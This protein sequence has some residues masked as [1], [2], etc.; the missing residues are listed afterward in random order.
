MNVKNKKLAV[1]SFLFLLGLVFFRENL[2]L[3]INAKLAKKDYDRSYSYWFTEFF[4]NLS[5]DDLNKW[6]WIVSLSFTIAIILLTIFTLHTWYG[7]KKKTT[8]VLKLFSLIII[9]MGLIGLG[10]MLTVGFEEVYPLLRRVIGVFHSPIPL[11]ILIFTL[12]Y[13]RKRKVSK[14][15]V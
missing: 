13:V 11:F 14:L 3:T 4:Q 1:V 10:G 2:L 6:K 7:D 15:F 9:I 5:V 12:L 8:L